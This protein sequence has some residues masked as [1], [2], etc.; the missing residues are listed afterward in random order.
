MRGVLDHQEIADTHLYIQHWPKSIIWCVVFCTHRWELSDWPENEDWARH[1]PHYST[2]L[3]YKCVC[4]L[5]VAI[6]PSVLITCILTVSINTD[7]HHRHMMRKIKCGSSSSGVIGIRSATS[8]GNSWDSDSFDRD[9][10]TILAKICTI[11]ITR[12]HCW[13]WF[14]KNIFKIPNRL[15]DEWK[16]STD[17]LMKANSNFKLPLL[18]IEISSDQLT[19]VLQYMV[20]FQSMF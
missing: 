2:A 18:S 16:K 10:K 5:I 8:Y 11:S 14:V 9:C 7:T 12:S 13:W 19:C 6:I 15:S 3:S 20:W 1:V 4:V 17:C